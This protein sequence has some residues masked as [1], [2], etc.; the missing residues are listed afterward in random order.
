MA[1]M[2]PQ[3]LTNKIK[4]SQKGQQME[5]QTVIFR[6]RTIWKRLNTSRKTKNA[7]QKQQKSEY[8]CRTKL[9][10]TNNVR[11]CWKQ[12]SLCFEL[13]VLSLWAQYSPFD[14]IHQKNII[15]MTPKTDKQSQGVTKLTTKEKSNS[16]FPMWKNME[17]A[18]YFLKNKTCESKQEKREI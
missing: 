13:D 10:S 15:Y 4:M 6:H 3:K 11:S 12:E 17:K 1:S 9:L 14:R 5:N 7:N 8:S 2:R 18:Q 16:R